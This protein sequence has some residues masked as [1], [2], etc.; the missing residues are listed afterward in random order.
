MAER[1][2]VFYG[3]MDVNIV[4]E[5]SCELKFKTFN[6]FAILRPCVKNLFNKNKIR[7]NRLHNADN[8]SEK[9]TE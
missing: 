7:E 6:S 5:D 2:K 9:R 1:R 8:E 3:F 4:Y